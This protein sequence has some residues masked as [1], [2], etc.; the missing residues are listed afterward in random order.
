M[1]EG[2]HPEIY[3]EII[4]G[5][6]I[7]KQYP[8]GGTYVRLTQGRIYAGPNH[9]DV[10]PEHKSKLLSLGWHASRHCE[11]FFKDIYT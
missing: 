1:S 2:T 8:S 11:V 5:F 3:D 9:N 7:F 10:T 4:V 6:E